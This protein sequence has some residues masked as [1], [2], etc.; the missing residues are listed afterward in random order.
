[1]EQVVESAGDA[2][3][4]L[5]RLLAAAVPLRLHVG[6]VLVGRGG[7]SPGEALSLTWDDVDPVRLLLHL[8]GKDVPMAAGVAEL[9]AWHAC[10]QRLDAVTG[11]YRWD[12]HGLVVADRGGR[13][14]SQQR[15][16]AITR[17][18]ALLAGLPP[19][20]LAALR[21]PWLR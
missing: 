9:L 17:R 5:D 14:F 1:M 13:P 8:P 12:P 3:S 18:T 10:R 21:H 2:G 19:V 4:P 15:A 7:L 20:P 16:D 6:M 11:G